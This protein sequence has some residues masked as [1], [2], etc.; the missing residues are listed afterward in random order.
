MPEAH[1]LAID[2][3]TTSTRCMCFNAEQKVLS[4]VQFEFKQY[5]PRPGWVEHDPDEIW[6]ATVRAAK[7]AMMKAGLKPSDITAV[8][9]TNQRRPQSCGTARRARWR[10]RPSSGSAAAPPIT[11]PA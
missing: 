11:A 2:E 8:G 6:Q 3:G 1:I 7:E 9:I 10:A 4:N 5:F